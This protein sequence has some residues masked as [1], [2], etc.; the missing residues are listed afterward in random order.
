MLMRKRAFKYRLYPNESQ[1]ALLNQ[2]YGHVRFVWNHCVEQFQQRHL[3]LSV[4]DLRALY[5]FLQTVSAASL[6]QKQ[7][8]FIETK[9]QFFNKKRKKRIRAP[10]FKKKR[11]GGSFRLPYPKF[12]LAGSRIRLEKIGEVSYVVDRPLPPNAKLLSVTV[13]KNA[14]DQHFVSLLVAMPIAPKPK[15]QH[16]VGCD[17]GLKA[18]VVTSEAAFFEP[19]Q[20]YRKNQAELQKAQKKRS[21]KKKGSNRRNKQRQKVARIHQKIVNQRHHYVHHVTTHLVDHYDTIVIEDLNV[22]GMGQNRKLAKSIYDA[23]FRQ[24][25]T[26][27]EYKCD[28]YAKK[29]VIADRFFASSK[30]CSGCG[31]QKITL[32]LA[33]RTFECEKCSL[34]L[35]RDLNAA[36]NLKKL[37]V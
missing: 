12:S 19:N 5:P 35:D 27:L 25:R 11:N 10:K 6:Q 28:W 14:S 20:S 22:Q 8:D 18:F 21:R 9:K 15:T 13:S 36:L 34:R 37:A 4:T 23:S 16:V 7:R 2:N 24:F 31:A 1:Q 29:L 3:P 33:E 26:Q 30:T 17:V 32:R